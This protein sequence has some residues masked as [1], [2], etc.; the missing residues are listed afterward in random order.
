MLYTVYS[1]LFRCLAEFLSSKRMLSIFRIKARDQI[2]VP[3]ALL[4]LFLLRSI[5]DLT[6][7]WTLDL[8]PR[9]KLNQMVV[10]FFLLVPQFLWLLR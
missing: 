10:D 3:Y 5:L 1:A 4:L 8:D 7:G 2:L 9:S 6:D